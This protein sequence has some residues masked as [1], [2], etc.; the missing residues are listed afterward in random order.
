M[1]LNIRSTIATIAILALVGLGV[2][3]GAGAAT[4]S[5]VS[6]TVT[7]ELISVSV[8]DGTVAFG[9][10]GLNTTEHTA[11][12]GNALETQI[13][14]NDGNVTANFG[15]RSS[16]AVSGGTNWELAASAGTDAFTHEFSVDDGSNWVAFNVDNSTYSTLANTVA[17][18]GTQDFDLRVG[19]PTASTDSVE[20]TV[21]VTVQATI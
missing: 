16:D 7:A 19:T 3:M 17:A 11:T 2:G 20:H 9:T 8:A 14:T 18:S 21:T 10:L 13:A 1:T 15:I 6:A 4:T 5:D 12:G